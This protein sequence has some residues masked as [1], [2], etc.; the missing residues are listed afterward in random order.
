MSHFH[1]LDKYPIIVQ[2]I[3]NE[4]DYFELQR[5]LMK[6]SII[7]YVQNKSALFIMMLVKCNTIL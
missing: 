5:L 7:N 3:L 4:I 6:Q 2:C 1:L